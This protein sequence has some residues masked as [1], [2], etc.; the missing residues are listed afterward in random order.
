MNITG[1]YITGTL[2]LVN[3]STVLSNQY[4]SPALV[5]GGTRTDP[6]LEIGRNQIQSKQSDKESAQFYI[7]EGGGL[8]VIGIGGLRIEG[9]LE[10]DGKIISKGIIESEK[11]MVAPTF[12]GVARSAVVAYNLPTEDVGGNIWIQEN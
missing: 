5:I 4:N 8:T 2:I 7:N 9:D 11:E 1:G 6:H 3:D 10:V 12:N